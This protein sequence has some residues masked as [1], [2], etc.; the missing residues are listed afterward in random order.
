MSLF[1]AKTPGGE[2][3]YMSG[4]EL[5]YS[6]SNSLLKHIDRPNVNM[7][8]KAEG[9]LLFPTPV[10]KSFVCGNDTIISLS[11]TDDNDRSGQSA[12][13]YLRS[14]HL[15]AFMYKK[16]NVWGPVFECSLTGSYRDESAPLYTGL[17]LLFGVVATVG[18]Y[19]AY[20]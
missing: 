17:T 8:L 12:K 3:F 15:Q 16:A 18:G 1:F 10:G 6:T 19:T 7:Y 4:A 11:P 14:N 5:R 2:R 13:L 20:R 9:L